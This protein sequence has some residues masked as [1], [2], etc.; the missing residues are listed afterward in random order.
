MTDQ[1]IEDASRK[2]FEGVL[3][4]RVSN[5]TPEILLE[6]RAD[7]KYASLLSQYSW[8]A[9]QAARQSSQSEPVA[10]SVPTAPKK[11]W[12]C[13]GDTD[14]DEVER[15][16]WKW[17]DLA[18]V[19]WSTDRIDQ[20]DIPYIRAD[21]AAPQQAIP[22]GWIPK[23]GDLVH[24]SKAVCDKYP[25][26]KPDELLKIVGINYKTLGL[27]KYTDVIDITIVEMAND[28]GATD[29][30]KLEDI[31]P[32]SPT[33]PI[34][35]DNVPDVRQLDELVSHYCHLLDNIGDMPISESWAAENWSK[36]HALLEANKYFRDSI[37]IA[38]P[39]APIGRDK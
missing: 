6:R 20:C 1:S 29:G 5:F 35:R 31:L 14:F 27:G 37:S 11:I 9:W 21:L 24:P 4:K 19:T 26:W 30:W 10:I 23:L 17:N 3:Q 18:E 28:Y 16:G 25:E 34:G 39:T 2:E 12:L 15:E 33:A 22:S 36:G 7:G 38:S 13:I 8:E 32:P